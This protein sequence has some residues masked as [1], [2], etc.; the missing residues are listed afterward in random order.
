MGEEKLNDIRKCVKEIVA[1]HND[2][3]DKLSLGFLERVYSKDMS[4][5]I[6]RLKAIGFHGFGKVL[7]AGCGFG[8]WS[9][10]LALLNKKVISL[11]IAPDRLMT[12][13][14]IAKENNINNIRTERGSLDKLPFEDS[15]F[16]S[17]FCYSSIYWTPWK[18]TISEF[19]RVLKKGGGMLYVN[20]NGLGWY[21]HLWKNMPN[22]SEDYDPKEYAAYALYNT[23]K[24]EKGE[25]FFQKFGLVIE[26]EELS[27]ELEKNNF[28]IIE[29]GDEGTINLKPKDIKFEPFF[30]G[31]YEGKTGVF[32]IL[33]KR[34]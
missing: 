9:I 2:I 18:K 33:A 16:D 24:Y 26:P 31:V 22:K 30:K 5:Y 19:V 34:R 12:L 3:L 13:N 17:I 32:E 20:A 28:E 10:G 21:L 7:D 4:V 29:K 11:D 23:F 14:K 8:Q 6:N 15:S 27:E 1:E 25:S